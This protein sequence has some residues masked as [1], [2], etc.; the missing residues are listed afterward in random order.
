MTIANEQ[1]ITKDD[2]VNKFNL[3]IQTYIKNKITWHTGN[4]PPYMSDTW[5]GVN[6]PNI[7]GGAND[8]GNTASK[9]ELSDAISASNIVNYFQQLTYNLT[10]VRNVDWQVWYRYDRFD[11]SCNGSW[12]SN[13]S[14]NNAYMHLNDNYRVSINPNVNTLGQSIVQSGNLITASAANTFMANLKKAYDDANKTPLNMPK[15]ICHSSCYDNCH[16]NRGRR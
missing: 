2:L 14:L 3:E 8:P 13:Y 10:K 11:D 12:W 5:Y 1:F 9:P 15:Y 16:G 4:M 7:L 6:N